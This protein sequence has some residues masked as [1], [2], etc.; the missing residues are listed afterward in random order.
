MS[1][2]SSNTTLSALIS[3]LDDPD[4]TAFQLIRKQILLLGVG[5]IAPLENYLENNFNNIVQ[6]RVNSIISELHHKHIYLEFSDWLNN[7]SSDLLKGFILVTKT[8]YPSLDED[9][10]V[11]DIAQLK[12]D[13]WVELNENLTAFENVKVFNHVFFDIHH[14]NGYKGKIAKPQ[15]NYVNGLLENKKGSPVSLGILYIILAQKLGLPVYGVNLPQHFVLVYLGGEGIEDPSENDVL[16]YINPFN[17]GAV[18]PRREIDLFN[19]QMKIKPEK[20]FFLPCSNADIIFRLI[21]NL[22]FSYNHTG[23]IDKVEVLETLLAAYE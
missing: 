17:M 9:E 23:E 11:S 18:F 3:L 7:G 6:Q 1:K 13:I 2:V 16:F 15:F 20:S 12:T 8:E 4:E 10:I 21:H 5:A 14:F 19:R 22:I